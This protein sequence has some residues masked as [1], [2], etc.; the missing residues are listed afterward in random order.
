MTSYDY[1]STLFFH[2]TN[3]NDGDRLDKSF[4]K[5]VNKFLKVQLYSIIRTGN[6]VNHYVLDLISQNKKLEIIHL[7]PLKLR[8]FY[9]F[10]KFIHFS[11]NK[12]PNTSLFKLIRSHEKTEGSTRINKYVK[13]HF[14]TKIMEFSFSTFSVNILNIF[15]YNYLNLNDNEFKATFNNFNYLFIYYTKYSKSLRVG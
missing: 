3:K 8:Y 2:N 12:T 14:K 15:L 6:K 11:L 10:I 7:L 9:H 4:S 5:S 13:P 1:C